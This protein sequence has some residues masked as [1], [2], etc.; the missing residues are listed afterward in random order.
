M[1]ELTQFESI[2]ISHASEF[3]ASDVEDL[4]VW[5]IVDVNDENDILNFV[6]RIAAFQQI[7]IPLRRCMF[8]TTSNV[9]VG[10]L[11]ATFNMSEFMRW[12]IESFMNLQDRAVVFRVLSISSEMAV[13]QLYWAD[14]LYQDGDSDWNVG[15]EYE[16][17]IGCLQNFF[18]ISTESLK[19][20]N[21]KRMTRR[22]R[23]GL[24][25]EVCCLSCSKKT[26]SFYGSCSW[27]HV[28]VSSVLNY[29]NGITCY[30]NLYCTSSK[31]RRNT[32][33]FRPQM[34]MLWW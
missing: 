31:Q 13:L 30:L 33:S 15:D 12:N 18:A 24:F 8:N 21:I 25:S 3:L 14:M 22:K 1:K 20:F 32:Y 5:R 2:W 16:I 29:I 10:A 27:Q 19:R 28:S 6:C 17:K 4:D 9:V 23:G 34:I 26:T 11:L 7:F